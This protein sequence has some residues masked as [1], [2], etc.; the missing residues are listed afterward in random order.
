[1]SLNKKKILPIIIIFI[2]V[3][4]LLGLGV[5]FFT[6]FFDHAILLRNGTFY[7][8]DVNEKVAAV[9]F[10]D[11]PSYDWTPRI[12]DALKRLNAK[13]TFFMIGDHVLKYPIVAKRVAA[14]GHD[15]GIH[16][17]GHHN[18]LYLTKYELQKDIEDSR[19]LI[20]QVTGKDTTL[21]RP[22]KAWLSKREK[23][24]IKSLGYTVVLWSLNSKD[25]VHFDDKYITK[26]ILRNIRPGDIILF[27]DSGGS[28]R[29]EGGDRKETVLAVTRIIEK[30]RE[31]GYR[32]VTISELLKMDK[33]EKR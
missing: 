2:A 17:M 16:S 7:R 18:Y 9:T 6:L 23:E 32:F 30:L 14:E 21:F 12:L 1:M 26:Y 29:L 22:P 11:G 15:I 31:S 8:A 5:T 19:A 24:K 13:A 4:A 20:R 25:W 10:D 3:L 27:H 28:F 33:N